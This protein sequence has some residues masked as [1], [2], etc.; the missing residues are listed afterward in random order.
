MPNLNIRLAPE[1]EERLNRLAPADGGRTQLTRRLL[2]EEDERAGPLA[3]Y[4]RDH[5]GLDLGRRVGGGGSGDTPERGQVTA[6]LYRLLDAHL[7]D[8][9]DR[10]MAAWG[11]EGEGDPEPMAAFTAD[12]R[13]IIESAAEVARRT[14]V[15]PWEAERDMSGDILRDRREHPEHWVPIA[16]AA[17]T[18]RRLAKQNRGERRAFTRAET[19]RGAGRPAGRRRT[20]ARDDG[21]DGDS[22]HE[23]QRG[24]Q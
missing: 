9:L 14:G 12:V 10:Q 22:D 20:V 15:R 6:F 3:E 7:P 23:V 11:A 1:D 17:E 2:R 8:W 19:A 13:A 24:A 5:P 4:L 21:E 16:E 18:Y